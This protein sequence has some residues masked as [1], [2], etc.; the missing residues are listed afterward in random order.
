MIFYITL[1]TLPCELCSSNK[2]KTIEQATKCDTLIILCSSTMKHFWTCPKTRKERPKM[3]KILKNN[4]LSKVW[5]LLPSEPN[6]KANENPLGTQLNGL[7]RSI[8]LVSHILL[9]FHTPK[10]SWWNKFQKI[11]SSWNISHIAL[12]TLQ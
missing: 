5:V 3:L 9:L 8:G 10:G 6:Y 11:K 1:S 7:R 12:G 4:H 2:I